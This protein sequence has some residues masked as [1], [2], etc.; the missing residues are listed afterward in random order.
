MASVFDK[1]NGRSGL[2]LD[3]G[4][5]P[6]TVFVDPFFHTCTCRIIACN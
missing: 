3:D 5:G 6:A 4:K 1:Q 2:V